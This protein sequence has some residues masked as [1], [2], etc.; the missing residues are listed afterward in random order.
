MK[1]WRNMRFLQWFFPAG[2]RVTNPV[3]L[4]LEDNDYKAF[5][6][7]GGDDLRLLVG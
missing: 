2:Y 4:M 1:L 6:M 3:F 7:S 5:V